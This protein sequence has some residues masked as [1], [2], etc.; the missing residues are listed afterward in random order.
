MNST[1]KIALIVV[2]FIFGY[3]SNN[4]LQSRITPE[5]QQ[6]SLFWDV[7]N[8]ME[9][10]YPF[11]QPDSQERLYAA[12]SGMVD[13]YGDD[14][15]LFLKPSNNQLFGELIHGEFAGAGMEIGIKNGNL[16]IISPLKDSPAER[17]GFMSGDIIVAVDGIPTA[18]QTFNQVL[19]LIRGEVGTNATLSIIRPADS[20]D[21]I[22]ITFTR[23]IIQIPVL[24]TQVIGDVFVISLYNFNETA[25]EAF[26]AAINEFRD[27][28]SK[29]LI[30]DLRNNP[31]GYLLV[32]IDVSSYF[33]DQGQVVVKEQFGDGD[34][35]MRMHRSFGYDVL[36][37]YDFD[38][39][40]LINEG[41]ASASE[42]VAGALSEYDVAVLAG[43]TTFGKGSVQEF[44]ELDEDTSLKVTVAK[45]LTPNGNQ[46]SKIGIEPDIF[47]NTDPSIGSDILLEQALELFNK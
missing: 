38:M 16:V 24:D 6:L 7:W 15:S 45:W 30:L 2:V 40:I 20:I 3:F 27:S 22:D 41:S 1:K 13:S 5:R 44:I 4:L 28:G 9:E 26:A 46:I 34:S 32:A 29:K 47:L 11:D 43:E 33:L 35:E 39:I 23:E 36:D 37:N 31:G 19:E 21:E 17:A 8:L 18:E 12:I 25:E 42:I 10:K 14:Y